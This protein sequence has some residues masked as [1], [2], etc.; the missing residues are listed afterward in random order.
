MSD[1][2]KKN[3]F[4]W[5]RNEELNRILFEALNK[6]DDDKI[7]NDE[8]K[9][10]LERIIVR[11]G[12]NLFNGYY[13]S[14][15]SWLILFLIK[16]I[17]QEN[18]LEY[19]I[20][21]EKYKVLYLTE[22]PKEIVNERKRLLDFNSP[23]FYVIGAKRI[24]FDDK[25]ERRKVSN[26][27][28]NYGMNIL[29][30]DPMRLYFTGDENKSHVIRTFFDGLRK[31]FCQKGISVILTHHRGKGELNYNETIA[32]ERKPKSLP[33]R[34]SSDIG[35]SCDIIFN[36]RRTPRKDKFE[37]VMEQDKNVLDPELEPLVFDFTDLPN[38]FV[39]PYFVSDTITEKFSKEFF[40]ILENSEETFIYRERALLMMKEFGG[41]QSLF[42][43]LIKKWK[44]EGKIKTIQHKGKTA[45]QKIFDDV[46]INN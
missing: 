31:D 6:K 8:E 11:N 28:L 43:K 27:M 9:Y 23:D 39:R 33:T 41:S 36:I 20:Y 46:S 3:E 2:I 14:G 35:A 29:I 25:E 37:I 32:I 45:Y 42:E 12:I 19:K 5:E 38:V 34:G 40:D 4:N 15:K 18:I 44:D 21:G 24:F 10:I 30:L 13:S 16:N 22:N 26:F 7:L 17:L 1:F